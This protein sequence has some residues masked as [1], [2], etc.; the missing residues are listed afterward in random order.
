MLTFLFNIIADN[1]DYSRKNRCT[2][3][4]LELLNELK[5]IKNDWNFSKL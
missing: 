5:I 1:F 4:Y 2:I 3:W